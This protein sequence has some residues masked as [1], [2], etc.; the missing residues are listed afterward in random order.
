[1]IFRK[2]RICNVSPEYETYECGEYEYIFTYLKK[3]P[4][5]LLLLKN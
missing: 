1:V 2:P 5:I 4:K 3:V